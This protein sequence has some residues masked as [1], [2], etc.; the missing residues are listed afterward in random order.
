MYQKVQDDPENPTYNELLIWVNLQQKNFNGAFIQA[1]A[2]DRRS[3][4]PGDRAMHIGIIALENEDYE[5][6][7]RIFDYIVSQ[8]PV[9]GN[10]VVARHYRIKAEEEIVKNTYPV[11]LQKI[12]DLANKYQQFINEIGLE[13]TTLDAYR[14]KALLH[15]FYLDEK[16]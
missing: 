8:Y 16:D 15:A 5:A 10:S 11:N 4:T 9:T 2:L 6:A 12:R 3:G 14:N 13:P 1:R 7:A